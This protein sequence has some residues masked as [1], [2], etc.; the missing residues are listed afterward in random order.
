MAKLDFEIKKVT[1]CDREEFIAMSREFYASEAVLHSVSDQY[2]KRAFDEL[3]RSDDYIDCLFFTCN[4]GIIGYALIV[5]TYSREAGG[6]AVWTD[7]LYVRPKYRGCGIGSTY[8]RW[9]EKNIPA[10]RYRLEAEPDN[11]GALRLYQRLGYKELSYTQMV[12]DN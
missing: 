7:E 10:A 1:D 4:K 9:L 8:F 11:A 12:K 3:M 5:K 2:H 6:L